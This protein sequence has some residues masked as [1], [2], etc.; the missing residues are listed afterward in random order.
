MVLEKQQFWSLAVLEVAIDNIIEKFKL[1]KIIFVNWDESKDLKKQF[2]D[3]FKNIQEAHPHLRED[4]CLEV[5]TLEEICSK[6]QVE[7]EFFDRYGDKRP[8]NKVD[9][10]NELCKKLQGNLHLCVK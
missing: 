3:K 6:Y 4:N 9:T 2:E 7:H 8:K 10:I 1:P 5:Y